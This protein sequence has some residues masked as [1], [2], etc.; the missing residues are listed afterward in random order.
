MGTS[1]LASAVDVRSDGFR[2]NA[3]HHRALA[4]DLRAVLSRVAAGGGAAAVARHR[5]RGKLLPRE[6]IDRLADPGAPFLELSPLA[7]W[8]VYEDEVPAAGLVTG[9]ARIAGRE[10]VVVANDATVRG[11][12][13]YPLTVKK[14]LRAQEIAAENRLPCVYLVDSGGAHLP[15]QDEVFPDRDGFGRIFYNQATMSAAAIP[16]IAVVLGSSTAGGAYVPAMADEAIIV[17]GQGTIFLG[18]PPLVRAATGEVVSAE[19]LGGAEVH[20]RTSGV[21]DHLA[22]DEGTPSRWRAAWWRASAAASSP[23]PTRRPRTRSTTRQELYG[24]VPADLRTPYDARELIARIVDGSALR[25]VQGPLRHDARLRVRPALGP[26]RRDRGQQRHPVLGVGPQ[27]HPLH[28]ALRAAAHPAALPAERDRLHGGPPLRGGRDRQGRRKDGERSGLR[29]R[30]QA[31]PHR[32]RQLRRRQ[33]RDVRPRLLA[34]LPVGLAQRRISVMGGE[35]AARVLAQVRR[36]A[37]A[38]RGQEWPEAEEKALDRRDPRAVRA[39]GTPLLRERPALG[40]RRDRPRRHQDR[41][42]A[43]A[44]RPRC[45]R[46]SSP[47][48][49]ASSGCERPTRKSAPRER[50]PDEKGILTAVVLQR[51]ADG[52]ARVTLARPERHNAFDDAI[53][54]ELRAALEDVAEDPAVRVVVLAAEG[55]SFS[56]GADLGWMRRMADAGEAEALA[57]ALA[58]AALLRRLHGMPQP[59]LAL[60]QGP[61]YG[62]GVGLVAACDLAVAAEGATFRLSEV[63][64]GLVPAVI[65]PYL[66]AAMGPRAARRAA[67][68]AETLDAGRALEVGL[69]DEVVPAEDLEDAGR[70]LVEQLLPNGPAAMREVKGLMDA[71]AGAP[72]DDRLEL[73]TAGRIAR[74]RASAEGREGVEAFL[75]RR[76]PRWAPPGS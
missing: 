66:V 50:R 65:A 43:R 62:G 31:H 4:E 15:S 32:R 76:P 9:V 75:E 13:Y 52:V 58:L 19:D 1:T 6:R 46:R 64:L 61:A 69:V 20:S 55:R 39:P 27:G 51:A 54:G 35:Q 30:P 29:A 2:R 10:C 36:E 44:H 7:A 3:E 70:R 22:V 23:C 57:D 60:V 67:L 73:D 42:R 72:L 24:I 11:G 14:H 37:L 59:T 16:Q 47:P 28:R 68:T 25:R 38:A 12:T 48:P 45:G 21:T 26:P 53:V 34:A 74:V 41:P 33:L 40:R 71:V 8:G 63:R 5:G 49:S 56:A 18:G 17:K